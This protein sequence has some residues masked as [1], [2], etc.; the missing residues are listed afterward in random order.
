MPRLCEDLAAIK[1]PVAS[2]MDAL[3]F[4]HIMPP[5]CNIVC[6]EGSTYPCDHVASTT[7]WLGEPSSQEE[8]AMDAA[9]TV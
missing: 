6:M 4:A 1:G 9:C 2:W 5:R 7:A 3:G 8:T